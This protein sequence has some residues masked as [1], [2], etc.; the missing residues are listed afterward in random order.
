MYLHIDRM[1]FQTTTELYFKVQS[2]VKKIR[3]YKKRELIQTK[4]SPSSIYTYR[5]IKYL[6]N[7]TQRTN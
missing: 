6:F 5:K 1:Q 7:F 4:I 2:L 3:K